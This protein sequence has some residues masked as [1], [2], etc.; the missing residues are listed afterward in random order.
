[1]SGNGYCF[2]AVGRGAFPYELLA[3][4]RCFPESS[5][6]AIN[7]FEYNET[8]RSIR[9]KSAVAPNNNLWKSYGWTIRV[10]SGYIPAKEDYNI[11]HTWPC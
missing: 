2:E 8:Y 6:D 10:I 7:A 5:E 1:M 9:L 3:N 11:Y 4:Q